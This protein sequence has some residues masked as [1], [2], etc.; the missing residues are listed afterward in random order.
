MQAHLALVIRK[1][2]TVPIE[3]G[4]PHRAAILAALRESGHDLDHDAACDHHRGHACS[5]SPRIKNWSPNG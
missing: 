1:D 4:H 3:D 5:C 2:G